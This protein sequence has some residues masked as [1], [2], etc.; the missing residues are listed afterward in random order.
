MALLDHLAEAD[1]GFGTYDLL[2]GAKDQ[3]NDVECTRPLRGHNP[4]TRCLEAN[5]LTSKVRDETRY[6][7]LLL[8]GTLWSRDS[9]KHEHGLLPFP[10]R[11]ALTMWLLVQ[12]GILEEGGGPERGSLKAIRQKNHTHHNNLPP[13]PALLCM[14]P[15]V[16]IFWV[17]SKKPKN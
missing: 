3:Y 12:F 7:P 11:L 8:L 17:T 15:N 1:V 2:E 4:G 5:S 16:V 6:T 9:Y 13:N 14:S 10:S